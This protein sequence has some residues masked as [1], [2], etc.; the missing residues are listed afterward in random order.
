VKHF[1]KVIENGVTRIDG[2]GEWHNW[3]KE[4]FFGIFHIGKIIC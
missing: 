1:P 4:V 3:T 2:Y